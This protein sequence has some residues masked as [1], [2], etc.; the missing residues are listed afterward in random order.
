MVGWVRRIVGEGC[1][2]KVQ[3]SK[4]AM[5]ADQ[6]TCLNI[7][8]SGRFQDKPAL[9]AVSNSGP[10]SRRT[11][12]GRKASLHQHKQQAKLVQCVERL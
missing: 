7:G 4:T 11:W 2:R 6:R 3:L 10:F 12:V 8:H 9:V 5:L 1:H